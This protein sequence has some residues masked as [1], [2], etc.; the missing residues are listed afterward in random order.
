MRHVLNS[1]LEGLQYM[2]DMGLIRCDIKP[3]NIPMRGSPQPRGCFEK[4][5]LAPRELGEWDPVAPCP[6]GKLQFDWQGPSSFEA[7]VVDVVVAVVVAVV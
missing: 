3:A 2:H 5:A 6:K 1:V 7:L 4:Q